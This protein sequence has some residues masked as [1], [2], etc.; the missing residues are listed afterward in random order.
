MLGTLT[1]TRFTVEPSVKVYITDTLVRGSPPVWRQD[2]VT[3]TVPLDDNAEL[4]VE[5]G[6]KKDDR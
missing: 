3:M 4:H 6:A 5:T 2:H 1:G